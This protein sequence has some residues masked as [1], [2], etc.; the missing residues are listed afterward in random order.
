[1]PNIQEYLDQR[2]LKLIKTH[3]LKSICDYGCG[4]GDLLQRISKRVEA[5]VS[6]TGIDYISLWPEEHRPVSN[7]RI[8]FIDREGNEFKK[9]I[10]ERGKYDLIISSFALHHYQ[11]PIKEL[12]TIENLLAHGGC[13]FIADL[14]FDNDNDSQTVKNISSFI[15]ETFSAFRKKYHRHHYTLEE[16]KDL[17]SSVN[18]LICDAHDAKV[19]IGNDIKE[20]TQ[21]SIEHADRLL[22][23]NRQFKNPILED[24]FKLTI[25][26]KKKILKKH[27]IDYSSMFVI[28][29]RK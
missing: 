15:D 17:L 20:D 9:L 5:D 24:F 10:K 28:V 18:L 3:S 29:A 12:N 25:D 21:H 4:N 14:N 11:Y 2:L 22:E 6:L 1:M 8:A 19:D 27:K 7:D 26:Y 13:L 16:A 23:L